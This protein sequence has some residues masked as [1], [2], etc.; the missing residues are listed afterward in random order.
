VK[1]ENRQG[2]QELAKK[3]LIANAYQPGGLACHDRFG[4]GGNSAL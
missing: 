4:I 1:E 3:S 2:R